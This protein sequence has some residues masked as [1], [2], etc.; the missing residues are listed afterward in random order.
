MLSSNVPAPVRSRVFL[1]ILRE[2]QCPDKPESSAD[3]RNYAVAEL[4][5]CPTIRPE[6]VFSL[7]EKLRMDLIGICAEKDADALRLD[8][9][10]VGDFCDAVGS[11][12]AVAALGLAGVFWSEFYDDYLFGDNIA[13]SPLID[14]NL[15]S[16]KT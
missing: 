14:A 1:A 10:S 8:Y 16:I 15:P 5:L 2:L 13:K 3:A 7:S 6:I 12:V 9:E 4:F 11:P